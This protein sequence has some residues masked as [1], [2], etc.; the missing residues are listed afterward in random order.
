M[1]I[2]P[3]SIIQRGMAYRFSQR[4][5]GNLA[6]VHPDLQRLAHEALALS[7]VD[8]MV[9]EGRRSAQRQAELVALGFSKTQYSRHLTGHAIDVA[10]II[11]GKVR[12][13]WPPFRVIAQAFKKAAKKLDIEMTWGGDWKKFPDGPHFEL[14]RRAYPAE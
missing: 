3:L 1:T 12:W 7:P 9:T 11:N 10:P 8:F 14:D 4:S 13:D 5:I 2:G 6:N